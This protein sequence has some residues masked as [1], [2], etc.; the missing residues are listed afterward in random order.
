MQNSNLLFSFVIQIKVQKYG[1]RMSSAPI[2][3]TS[4][5]KFSSC[6]F[7]FSGTQVLWSYYYLSWYYYHWSHHYWLSQAIICLLKI[8]CY[9]W[10]HH[11]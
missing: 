5:L 2:Y 4:V 7:W 1:V 11:W 10:L 8:L 9:F 6:N 3:H